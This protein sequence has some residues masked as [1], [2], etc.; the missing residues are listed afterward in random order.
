MEKKKEYYVYLH[1][2]GLGRVFYVG[3]GKG[4]RAKTKNGRSVR[5]RRHVEKYQFSI[6]FV[7]QEMTEACA[8]TLE[9]ITI[10]RFGR[11]NLCN[12]TDGGEGTSGHIPS[13]QHRMK[14]SASNKGKQPA[15][16]TIEMA[17]KKTKKKVGTRCGLVFESITDA[18]RFVAIDGN[19]KS[20]K[21]SISACCRGRRV[22]QCYGYEF[23]YMQDGKL[24][25]SG[26]EPKKIGKPV[27]ND[28]GMF[29]ETIL[30]A[31]RWLKETGHTKAIA[32]NISQS[33]L[34]QRRRAYGYK[35]NYA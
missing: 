30:E 32:S 2:D 27:K 4:K 31:E 18:A 25:D 20:A 6:E 17:L 33:C 10:A 15:R 19:I 28:I 26:F 34:K 23:R 1:R 9:R 12:M 35:W 16:H 21:S 29:F 22:G 14:C 5:W 13:K 24:L 11:I 7:S 3:K 8:H